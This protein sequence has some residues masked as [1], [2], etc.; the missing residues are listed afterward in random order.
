MV[1]LVNRGAVVTQ[2]RICRIQ[3][4]LKRG[5]AVTKG[6]VIVTERTYRVI[7]GFIVRAE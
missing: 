3:R 5:D 1:E 4:I 6:R 7:N 2:G